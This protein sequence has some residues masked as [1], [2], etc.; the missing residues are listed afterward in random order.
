[1]TIGTSGTGKKGAALATTTASTQKKCLHSIKALEDRDIEA[2][3]PAKAEPRPGKVIP[4]RRFKFDPRHNIAR[5]PRGKIL[6]PK[7]KP[8]RGF[9][10]FHASSRD[11]RA[12]PLQT[13][14]VS[15]S[16]HSR[17]VVFNLNHPSLLRAR[18][19]RIAWGDREQRLYQRHRWR[20]EGVHGEAKTW[21]GLARAVRRGLDNMRIQA[22]L[23][24]AAINLKRLAAAF[25]AVLLAVIADRYL[26]SDARH[27]SFS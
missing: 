14:C 7:G 6:R 9:Q 11:C 2:I 15:S 16:R 19:K 13:R 12:C 21:H 8:H 27:P 25:I 3:V 17:V 1:M 22:F 5:C 23:T 4:T 18:R 26:R 10:Y 20:V 24:A